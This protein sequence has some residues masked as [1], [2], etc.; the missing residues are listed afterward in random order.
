VS[1]SL[2][3]PSRPIDLTLEPFL[4]HRYL[5]N[6]IRSLEFFSL[7]PLKYSLFSSSG[8]VT[9]VFVSLPA[10]LQHLVSA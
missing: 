7:V 4:S 9:L 10:R 6:V 3:S 8:S 1:H 5:T 2:G